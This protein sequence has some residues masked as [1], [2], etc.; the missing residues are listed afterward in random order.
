MEHDVAAEIQHIPAEMTFADAVCLGF[1]C[2][3]PHDPDGN[4]KP[5]MRRSPP[6]TRTDIRSSAAR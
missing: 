6:A 3:W 2:S 1:E 5:K 4:G